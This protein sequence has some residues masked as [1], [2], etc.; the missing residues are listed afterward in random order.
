MPRPLYEQYNIIAEIKAPS[1]KFKREFCE[2][3]IENDKTPK[4]IN[5]WIQSNDNMPNT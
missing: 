5:L 1:D 2:I 3:V 4:A